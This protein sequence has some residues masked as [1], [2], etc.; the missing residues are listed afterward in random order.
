MSITKKVLVIVDSVSGNDS[1]LIRKGYYTLPDAVDQHEWSAL[2]FIQLNSLR[3]SSY[4]QTFSQ[5]EI[6]A[7]NEW[8]S[9]VPETDRELNLYAIY[10]VLNTKSFLVFHAGQNSFLNY[11]PS[12]SILQ[13]L[14]KVYIEHLKPSKNVLK[15]NMCAND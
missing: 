2:S 10:A 5:H 8:I 1:N 9:E 15:S 12:D 7:T 11:L 4:P 13:R 14:Q 6:L 3:L